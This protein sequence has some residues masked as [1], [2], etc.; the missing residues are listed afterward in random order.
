ML[1]SPSIV[2]WCF[3]SCACVICWVEC[4]YSLGVYAYIERHSDC[5]MFVC[6]VHKIVLASR[7]SY[8]F[9]WTILKEPQNKRFDCN[10]NQH[11]YV[12]L[13]CLDV[14]QF[15]ICFFGNILEGATA[16]AH[17][18]TEGVKRPTKVHCGINI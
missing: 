9:F 11:R 8:S 10:W 13:L 5:M 12:L 7:Q 14:S 2:D 18:F 6:K 15:H 3:C 1:T 4:V 17:I 16:S